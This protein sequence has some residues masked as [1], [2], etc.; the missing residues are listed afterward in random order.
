MEDMP[1]NPAVRNPP[2]LQ[3]ES[4]LTGC[5]HLNFCHDSSSRHSH[6]GRFTGPTHL[7]NLQIFHQTVFKLT[8]F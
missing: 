5:L 8:R 6:R 2:W 4:I 3:I 7:G 1:V